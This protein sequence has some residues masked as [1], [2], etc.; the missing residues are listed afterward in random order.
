L[1]AVTISGSNSVHTQVITQLLQATPNLQTL[2]LDYQPTGSESPAL[3]CSSVIPTWAPLLTSL[4]LKSYVTS[5][6]ALKL[7]AGLPS[8][9]SLHMPTWEVRGAREVDALLAATRL[10]DLEVGYCYIRSYTREIAEAT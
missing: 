4:H 5:D 10:T 1:Q 9:A 8:L 6:A 7:L 2:S 3:P